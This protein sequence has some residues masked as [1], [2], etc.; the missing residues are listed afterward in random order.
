MKNKLTPK[1]QGI[2]A[3]IGKSH[4]PVTDMDIGLAFDKPRNKAQKWAQPAV[5]ELIKQKMVERG[6]NGYIT[7]E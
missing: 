2:M 7:T 5:K 4:S 6:K 3:F 1:Q